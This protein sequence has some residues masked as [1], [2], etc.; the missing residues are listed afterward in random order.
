MKSK[1]KKSHTLTEAPPIKANDPEV[2]KLWVK[3]GGRCEFDGCNDYLLEDEFTGF[4]VNLADIAHIIG[5][6]KS[7]LSPRGEDR[8]PIKDRNKAENLILL[9]SKHHNKIVDKKELLSEFPKEVLLKYKRTHEERIRYVTGLGPERETAVICMVG[10]IRGDA[11][12]IS[13]E[14]IRKAVWESNGRY[15]RYFASE[16]NIKID[17]TGLP[18]KEAE[19]YWKSGREIIDDS[20]ERQIFAAIKREKINHLSILALARIPF[21]VYLG[22]CLGDKVCADIYQKHRDGDEGWIWRKE[23][24]T[25]QFKSNLLQKGEKNSKVALILSISG[26]ISLEQLP[27]HINDDFNIYEIEPEEGTKPNRSIVTLESTLGAFRSIYQKLLREIE[28]LHSN[29]KE[30]HLFPAIPISVAIICGREL[31]KTVSPSLC[32]YDKAT[33]GYNFTMEVN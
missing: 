17:L 9:C 24:E 2:L 21:L 32:V 29:A 13:G 6:K 3:A 7:P 12:S 15:P 33:E 19:M 26:K 25:V 1:H 11:V 27:N 10:N 5:R 8:L 18:E 30:I 20:I 28:R 31:M 14:E 16:N 4:L 22:H 23:G